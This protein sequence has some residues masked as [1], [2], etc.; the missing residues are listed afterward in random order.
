[1]LDLIKEFLLPYYL[2]I[3]FIH[4]LFMAVWFMST[5]VAYS[6]FVQVAFFQAEKRPDDPEYQRR[7]AWA[8]EQFDKGVVMEHI[9]FPILLITGPLMYWL[10][11][12]EIGWNWL[13]LKLLIVIGIFIPLEILDYW[14]S[15]F[16]G[17]KT[18]LRKLGDQQRYEQ[19][20]KWH[21]QFL[22]KST[23]IVAIFI[24]LIIF[25][26]VVKPSF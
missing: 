1:M 13:G 7:K 14:L 9:A 20:V 21:W 8:L 6:W 23:P 3:K 25:L 12:W 24:P 2:Y 4:V 26:A 17:N 11:G 5:A 16:G 15:H 19:V 18:Y 22:R 10:V